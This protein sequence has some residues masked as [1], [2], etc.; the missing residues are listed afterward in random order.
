MSFSF[1]GED[2]P[3]ATPLDEDDV[4][5]LVPMFVTTR[6]ELNQMEQANIES[7]TVWAFGGRRITTVTGLL[8]IRFADTVH[9]RMFGDV[10]RWAGKHRTRVTNIGVEPYRII[11]EMKLV[12]DD[13]V[14]WHDNY[15]YPPTERAV[16]LHHRLVSVH[17]YRHGNGRHARFMADLYL[18]ER[19]PL[20]WGAP[21]SLEI[22]GEVR[23]TYID[24][25]RSA[26]EGDIEPLHHFATA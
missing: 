1:D 14:S 8:T 21:R 17:P 4:E 13:A 15:T 26:D 7:A 12:L 23:R 11:T 6:D 9:R 3:H 5:G 16:R 10:W 20:T 25:L 19:A 22:E 24:A 18:A 2:P